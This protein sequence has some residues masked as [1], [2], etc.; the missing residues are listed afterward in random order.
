MEHDACA[1]EEIAEGG[2]KTVKVGG[3]KVLLLRSGDEV[4]AV[5]NRCPH[6]KMPLG[7]GKFDGDQ[8]TCRFHG[9]R[10][11]VRTGKREKKA[12]LLGGLGGDCLPTYP[13]SLREGRV[14]VDMSG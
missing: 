5:D 10:W 3:K 4:L 13:V 2:K 9:S 11:D 6:M 7:V 8:I 12:W 1:I 14:F